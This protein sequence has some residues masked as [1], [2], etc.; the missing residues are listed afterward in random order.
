MTQNQGAR[1]L[2]L[3]APLAAIDAHAE[4]I[5]AEV[6]AVYRE[7]ERAGTVQGPRP[8]AQGQGCICRRQAR[9]AGRQRRA[10]LLGRKRCADLTYKSCAKAAILIS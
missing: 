3:E 10:R 6:V 5:G 2:C 8:C 7:I 1:G 4:Q 9:Q